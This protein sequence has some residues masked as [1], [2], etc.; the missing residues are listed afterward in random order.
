MTKRP[1]ARPLMKFSN[2]ILYSR[3]IFITGILMLILLSVLFIYEIDQVSESSNVVQRTNVSRKS[4]QNIYTQLK[5]R[6]SSIRLFMMT[7]DLS[8]VESAPS[9][10]SLWEE[11]DLVDSLIRSNP[12][13][14][15]NIH[16]LKNILDSTLHIQNVITTHLQTPAYAGSVRFHRDLK[17]MALRMDSLRILVAKI[18]N[19]ETELSE[20]RELDAQKHSVISTMIGVGVC[21]FSMIIFVI[22][23]Y[24]IDQELKRSQNYARETENLNRKIAEINKQMEE[25][26]RSLQQL[27][28]ELE[29][30]NFQLERYASELSSFTHITSHDMQEP[31]R[32]IEFYISIVEDREKPNLSSEGLKFLNKT[33]QSVKR[34][35]HLFLSMI[36]F[37]LTNV[38]DQTTEDVDLN[39]VLNQTLNSLKV[40]IKDTNAVIENDPLP[41]VKGI[42]YQLIQ[43]F[44][45]IVSNAIKFRRDDV[46]PEIQITYEALDADK[47]NLRGLQHASKYYKLDFKDNGI[48][49]DEKYAEKIFEIFQRL[50]TKNDSYGVGIGL[51]ICRKIAENHGGALVASSQPGCGSVF[52]LYLPVPG[53]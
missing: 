33:K 18:Q 11:V 37:S 4:L 2:R 53:N 39:E 45:N 51:A 35:R 12:R 24:F 52:T 5:D 38:A 26:N 46:F 48:G 14:Q 15:N 44:E 30:K 19:I 23:F 34:M 40:Y 10:S 1:V 32:K 36:D 27:N 43:L 50:I 3:S 7:S 21:I 31:L 8:R 9:F 29:C 13:Q 41:V 20:E 28:T 49:F 47:L 42:K 6:E 16:R 25:A 22:A 17:T